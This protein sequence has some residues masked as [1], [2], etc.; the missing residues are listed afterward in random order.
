MI[1]DHAYDAG[2]P[3]DDSEGC[4]ADVEINGDSG[5]YQP[6]GEP[7][8]KHLESEYPRSVR[9]PDPSYSTV[10]PHD[11]P[12]LYPAS[13]LHFNDDSYDHLHPYVD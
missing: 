8:H 6:C 1:T 4:I 3:R 13:S 11:E 2:H 12:D 10:A 5:E 9:E 7:E